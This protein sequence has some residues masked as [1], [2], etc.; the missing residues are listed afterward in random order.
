MS[1]KKAVTQQRSDSG[2]PEETGMNSAIIKQQKTERSFKY[3]G[4]LSLNDRG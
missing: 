4:L 1:N 3:R 2:V